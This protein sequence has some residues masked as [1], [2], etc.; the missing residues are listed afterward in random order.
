MC[1]ST[2]SVHPQ[3][4]HAAHFQGGFDSSCPNGQCLTAY[5]GQVYVE[6]CSS[7]ANYYEQWYEKGLG[8]GDWQLVNRMS[9]WCLDSN[10]GGDVYTLPCN[11]G[12]Y[13]VWR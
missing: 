5:Q 2:R 9:G 12:Q 10:A 13:Q 8:N 11:G 7:P 4:Q 1:R 3:R 6:N